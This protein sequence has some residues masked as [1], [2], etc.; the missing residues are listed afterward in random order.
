MLHLAEQPALAYQGGMSLVLQEAS[1]ARKVQHIE[2][3][4]HQALLG[5]GEALPLLP[6]RDA[7]V[8][9]DF[10]KMPPKIGLS[11]AEGRARLLHDLA[12]IEMQAMELAYRGLIEYADAPPQFREELAKLTLEEASHLKLCLEG[13]DELGY[14]WGHWPIHLGLW[15][16]V[17]PNEEILDRV[18][19]VHRYLEGSGLDAGGRLLARLDGMGLRDASWKAVE[20]IHREEIGHVDFG[21]RWFRM[22]CQAE[23]LDAENEFRDR[24]MKLRKQLP[25]RTEPLDLQTRRLAGFSEQELQF[26]EEWRTNR[27]RS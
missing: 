22:L 9:N 8:L 27:P 2:S 19:I 1:A 26:L 4:V 20:T 12:N 3:A 7:E 21:S 24:M 18:L 13:L 23:G 6:A 14:S 15:N 16:A 11:T 25:Y 5:R 17:R 10:R